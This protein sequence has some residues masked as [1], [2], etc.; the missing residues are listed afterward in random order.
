MGELEQK[1]RVVKRVNEFV[2]RAEDQRLT[3]GHWAS[4]DVDI[5]DT[6]A[7]KELSHIIEQCVHNKDIYFR[8]ISF[9]V[10][11]DPKKE[12][13]LLEKYEDIEPLPAAADINEGEASDVALALKGTFWV[14]H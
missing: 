8:P 13:A 6:L 11:V 5:N 3:P 1:V 14:R 10:T 2:G 4:Y 9:H 7:F 12:P